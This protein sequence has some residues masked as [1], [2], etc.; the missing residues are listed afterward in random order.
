MS[1]FLPWLEAVSSIE[2][3]LNADFAVWYWGDY[4][5]MSID[6]QSDI[7]LLIYL[8]LAYPFYPQGIAQDG[9]YEVPSFPTSGTLLLVA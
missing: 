2:Y 3:P 1:Q 8:S 4:S 5:S 7:K 9:P 6:V